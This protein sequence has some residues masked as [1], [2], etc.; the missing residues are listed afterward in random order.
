MD[1]K[2]LKGIMVKSATVPES[3]VHFNCS[4]IPAPNFVWVPHKIELHPTQNINLVVVS[5]A[6]CFSAIRKT[7]CY[8]FLCLE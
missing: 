1:S 6:I 3:P 5:I 4:T 2:N 8:Y 7:Y